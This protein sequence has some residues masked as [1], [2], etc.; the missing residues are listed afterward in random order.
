MMFSWADVADEGAPDERQGVM[1]AWGREGD[2][3][4]DHLRQFAA[5]T[6]VALGREDRHELSIAVD[7]RA[8][9][10]TRGCWVAEAGMGQTGRGRSAAAEPAL[11][12]A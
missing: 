9:R 2:R 12:A 10:Y 3:A 11:E 7:V 5:G 4:L 1:L 8:A 6:A